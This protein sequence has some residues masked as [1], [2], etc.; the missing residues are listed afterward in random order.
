MQFFTQ[1][2]SGTNV[3]HVRPRRRSQFSLGSPVGGSRGLGR[4]TEAQLDEVYKVNFKG[5]FLLTLP[6]IADG[7]RIPNVSIGLARMTFL[8]PASTAR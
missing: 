7:G 2:H 6:L 3:E 8:V 4:S 5:P 1:Q